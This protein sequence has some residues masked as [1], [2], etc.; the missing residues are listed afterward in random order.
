MQNQI[1]DT[2]LVE[3]VTQK[4]Q[5]AYKTTTRSS[6]TDN[7]CL[8]CSTQHCDT[9]L[10]PCNHMIACYSCSLRCKKCLLCKVEISDRVK[11]VD[12]CVICSERPASVLLEPCGHVCACEKCAELLKKCIQCRAEIERKIGFNELRQLQTNA[13]NNTG[14]TA[15]TTTTGNNQ[16]TQLC[17]VK[18][19]K[20]QLQE[21]KEQ[22]GF[23]YY[24]QTYL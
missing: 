16:I 21:I 24:T 23:C 9:L 12:E 19:L 18:K 15:T 14:A 6:T 20:Q 13:V 11:V 22:V 4:Q 2:S 5:F 17:D 1:V 3:D 10:K 7:E 8:I